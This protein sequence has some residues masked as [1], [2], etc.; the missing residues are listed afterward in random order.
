MF[1]GVQTMHLEPPGRK[2]RIKSTPSRLYAILSRMLFS[3]GAS[4]RQTLVYEPTVKTSSLKRP[5]FLVTACVA[6]TSGFLIGVLLPMP[7]L[8]SR[9]S[10]NIS[11]AITKNISLPQNRTHRSSSDD[12]TIFAS[13][14]FVRQS[15]RSQPHAA[16]S[17]A[18]SRVVDGVFWTH[19]A[20]QMLPRGFD[21]AD[22]DVWRRFL[23]T[24]EVAKLE[25][26]C[27]RMQNRLITFHD[28]TRACCR[29]RQNT[30][31]IQG[32]L[33]S[34]Y[35]GRILNINNLVPSSLAVVKTTNP[36]W[37]NVK[38]QVL[39]SQWMEERPIIMTKYMEDLRPANIPKHLQSENRRLHPTDIREDEDVLELVQW[40]DLIV[41]DYLTANLDRI[42]NNLYNL[43]W[44]PGMMEAPAHNLAKNN[45]GLLLFLDNES[46]LLH[47][48]RLLEKYEAYHSVL[49]EAL[50]V[51]R[52]STVKM[53]ESL[54]EK[55]NIGSLLNEN[56]FN[57]NDHE[58]LPVLPE[59]SVKILNE[60][61]GKVLDQVSWCEKQ[62]S[63]ESNSVR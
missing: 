45:D 23:Q 32:E 56:L 25:E 62:Y 52:R 26:G 39:T 24:A 10:A 44:N 60:R 2:P 9:Q 17:T 28:G 51:F 54:R 14:S 12:S 53:L 47:G 5:I 22:A 13:V 36:L 33:F 7:M 27:G 34:F 6:F 63:E 19:E 59:K 1:K 29:Y 61:I 21:E 18:R 50:C 38:S 57:L 58:A 31:Q 16:P 40:S 4:D 11:A 41:F 20:E 43:Q 3:G 35:L 37:R 55:K 30:D 8:Q 46:G 48:Y 49:L 15:L 42:V